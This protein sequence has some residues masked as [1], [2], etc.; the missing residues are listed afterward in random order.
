MT[1]A[2]NFA[3]SSNIVTAPK[4]SIISKSHVIQPQQHHTRFAEA[5]SSLNK[6]KHLRLFSSSATSNPQQ[7]Q[8]SLDHDYCSSSSKMKRGQ[9]PSNNT[10]H[11]LN[12]QN[13]SGSGGVVNN[14]IIS[15]SRPV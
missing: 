15:T 14:N 10:N 5:A 12:H 9:R 7:V 8:I 13:S 11:A 1:G 6:S 2:S 3:Q 4:P